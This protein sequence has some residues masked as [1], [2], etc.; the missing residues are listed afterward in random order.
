MVKAMSKLPK[1]L[2]M[3]RLAFLL[4][5]GMTSVYTAGQSSPTSD[6][7]KSASVQEGPASGDIAHDVYRNPWFGFSCRIPYGWVERTDTMREASDDP[8]KA[9]VLLAVFERPPEAAGS[10]VN[11]GIV[12]AAEAASAYPGIKNAAQYFGPLNE[13]TSAQG[14]TKVNEPYEFPVDGKPIVRQDFI[15]KIGGV[16]LHQS[17]LAWLARGYVV[18][19][20]FVGSNDDEVQAL[21]EGLKIDYSNKSAKSQTK[22]SKP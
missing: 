19:F 15:K 8:K 2:W 4:A 9:M 7:A 1:Q 18:S 17:T 12:I 10:T 6:A 14:L 16:G 20:T 11:S 3:L 22:A 21:I 5:L 13:V